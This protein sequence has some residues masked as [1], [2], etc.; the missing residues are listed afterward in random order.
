MPL[1]I[2]PTVCPLSSCMNVMRIAGVVTMLALG[3]FLWLM[4]RREKYGLIAPEGGKH[5]G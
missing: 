3:I 4:F 2:K 5:S 1:K